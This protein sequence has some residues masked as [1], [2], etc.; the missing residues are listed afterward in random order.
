MMSTLAYF[1]MIDL[2]NFFALALHTHNFFEMIGDG[3][4]I[5]LNLVGKMDSFYALHVFHFADQFH[6]SHSYDK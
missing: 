2:S 6:T 1:Y 5:V 3:S 4:T